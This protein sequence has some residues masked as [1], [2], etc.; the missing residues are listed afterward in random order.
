MDKDTI[1]QEIVDNIEKDEDIDEL[2]T[3][4]FKKKRAKSNQ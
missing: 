4:L 1:K 2:L 3:E